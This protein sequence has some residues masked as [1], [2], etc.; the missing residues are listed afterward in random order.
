MDLQI[1][2]L[3]KLKEKTQSL[4][5]AVKDLSQKATVKIKEIDLDQAEDHFDKGKKLYF[6]YQ[7]ILVEKLSQHPEMIEQIRNTFSNSANHLSV[8]GIKLSG[9]VT[10]F[11]A[12][13][14]LLKHL[15]GL[16][17][18]PSTVYDKALDSEY[19]KTHI[20]GGNHRLFDGGHDLFAAWN[21]IKEAMADDTFSEEVVGYVSALWKD[22]STVKGLPFATFS[23]DNYDKWADTV[24]GHIPGL[25]RKY[26]YDLLSFDAYE[27]LSTGLGA[28]SVVFALS[29]EDQVKLS[30]ILG[31]M[32]IVSIL[33]ANP[34]MGLFLI[35]TSGYAFTQTKLK[36]NRTVFGKS[37]IATSASMTL[38]SILGLPILAELV[39][40]GVLTNVLRKQVLDNKDFHKFVDEK[41]LQRFVELC[42]NI[43]NK[44]KKAA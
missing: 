4:G 11:L 35:V 34:L 30:E 37:V 28:V 42:K 26:L 14:D 32:G 44:D 20:G 7:R 12:D 27:L 38:F 21:K 5:H 8:Q 16:T 17:K 33:S 13:D 15:E 2:S 29:K 24:A 22:M 39:I 19:L 43:E 41:V 1:M 31:S 36:L 40:I 9:A 6:D 10:S 25:D 23:K 18:L 3:K